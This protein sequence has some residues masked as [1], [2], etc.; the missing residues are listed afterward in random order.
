M[1]LSRSVLLVTAIVASYVVLSAVVSAIVALLWKAGWFTWSDIPARARAGRLAT[2]RVLPPAVLAVVTVFF[3]FPLFLAAEPPH[4]LEEVGPALIVVGLIGVGLAI[5]AVLIAARTIVTTSRIKRVWL[6]GATPLTLTGVSR[7]GAY[8]IASAQPIVALVGIVRPSFVVARV[9]VDAC[10]AC[11][12]ANMVRHERTHLLAHDNLKRL[13]MACVPDVLALTPYHRA[14]ADAWH[15]AAEDAADDAATQ[16]EPRARL[17]LAA[18]LLKVAN[19]TPTVRDANTSTSL[20]IDADGLERRVRRLVA[21]HSPSRTQPSDH[22]AGAVLI[23]IALL[24][25][26][27]LFSSTARHIV[28]SAVEAVVAAGAPGR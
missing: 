26:T 21:D 15:D 20:F 16:G 7:I 13:L 28:H 25:S 6:R 4:E 2:L 18:L 10:T 24:V 23:G 14:I 11:E 1:I 9:V 3:V 19:L 22:L 5:K 17:D 12:I 27:L 8:Q